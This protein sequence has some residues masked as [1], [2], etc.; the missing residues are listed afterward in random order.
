MLF[1]RFVFILYLLLHYSVFLLLLEYYS[2]LAWI[3]LLNNF[4]T[5]ISVVIVTLFQMQTLIRRQRLSSS[6]KWSTISWSAVHLCITMLLILDYFEMANFMV[7]LCVFG[8]LLTANI[9]VVGICSCYVI[10]LNGRSWYAHV[11]LTCISFWIFV[12]FINQRVHETWDRGE[13][14]YAI[15]IP[16]ISMCI[17]R[18]W[19]MG[20]R[21]FVKE[22]I[23][24]VICIGAHILNQQMILSNLRF[25]W[26]II[27]SI[28]LMFVISGEWRQVCL[29][30]S[31]PTGIT[32]IFLYSCCWRPNYNQLGALIMK[33]YDDIFENGD[34]LITI[35][36]EDPDDDDW[37]Q[38]L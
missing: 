11:H 35:P 20:P 34:D 38:R 33:K 15:L 23:L 25:F 30:A 29:L 12:Q 4:V 37:D 1:D 24:W 13:L 19:E 10:I 14:S 8:L 7:I 2:E 6:D 32:L 28:F 31:L 17:L 18:F 36:L 3:P 5:L 27:G 9:F 22:I 21:E 26:A 16:I